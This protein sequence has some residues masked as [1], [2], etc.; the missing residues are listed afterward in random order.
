MVLASE[1][2]LYPRRS[3]GERATFRT[4]AI[5]NEWVV[6]QQTLAPAPTTN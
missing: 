6:M 2:L 4:T 1:T 3:V 5:M